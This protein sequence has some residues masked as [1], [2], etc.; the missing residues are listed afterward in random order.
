MLLSSLCATVNSESE[1]IV[2]F[3]DGVHLA[4]GIRKHVG[5]VLQVIRNLVIHVKVFVHHALALDKL[6]V[7]GVA[8]GFF[9]SFIEELVGLLLLFN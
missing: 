7:L 2:I 8:L 4:A 5:L 3:T 6:I 1:L 9:G